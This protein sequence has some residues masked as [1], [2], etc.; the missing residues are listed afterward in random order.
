MLKYPIPKDRLIALAKL[1]FQ[2]SVTPGM[3]TPIIATCADGFKVLTKSKHKITI[4]D[5]R[6]PWKPVYDIL[7]QDLFLSR[8]QFEYTLVSNVV[9][10]IF[11]N[12]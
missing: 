7:S 2:L 9:I 3:P 1:Y 4:D 6:L 8:R 12:N 10:T 11:F 5:M